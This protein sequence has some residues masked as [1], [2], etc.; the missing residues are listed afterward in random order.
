MSQ[1]THQ[2]NTQTGNTVSRVMRIGA[3]EV[4][5]DA[6]RQV[7]GQFPGIVQ[8]AFDKQTGNLTAAYDTAQLAFSQMLTRLADAG[9]KP[10]DTW[11]FRFTDQNTTFQ[12][13]AKPKGCCN[14]ISR[15]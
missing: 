9:I 10:V 12:T 6:L 3:S 15:A 4:S 2:G 14:S 1:T 7:E 11:R 13:Y 5:E 8:L